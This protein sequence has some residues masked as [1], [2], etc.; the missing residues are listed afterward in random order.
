MPRIGMPSESRLAPV[1]IVGFGLKPVKQSEV[2][3]VQGAT[4]RSSTL[5]ELCE[6]PTVMSQ[7]KLG[8][9]MIAA[10]SVASMPVFRSDPRLRVTVGAVLR[11]VDDAPDDD[12]IG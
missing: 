3:T 9:S 7:P 5:L 2:L 8:R 11:A 6:P 12:A 4:P 10:F 1:P